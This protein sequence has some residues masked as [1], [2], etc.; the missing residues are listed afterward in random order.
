MFDEFLEA[1]GFEPDVGIQ[2]EKIFAAR[3][4]RAAIATAAVAIVAAGREK[5]AVRP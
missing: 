5:D 2:E 4:G 1:I 3:D